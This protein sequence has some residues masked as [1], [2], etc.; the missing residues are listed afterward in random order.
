MLEVRDLVCG[1]GHLVAVHGVSFSVSKGEALAILGANGAG[2]TSTLMALAGHVEIKG[3]SVVFADEDVT[4]A[5]PMQRCGRGI[6]VTPEGRRLFSDMTV[7]ENL[8]VGGYLRPAS[9]TKQNLEKA[10]E[11]FPRLKERLHNRAG[12]LSGGEQQMVSIGRAMMAE[13]K[14]LLIDEVSLGLMP[15][16]VDICYEALDKL[17]STGLTIIL[18]EQS[19]ERVL[20]IADQVCVLDSGRVAWTGSAGEARGNPKILDAYMGGTH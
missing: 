12:S 6:A 19:L 11:L 18:V 8:I 7:R 3:G 10:L 13:P 20:S 17:R 2:K 9:R 15:K 5:T 4:R 14:L 1:Y 16:N